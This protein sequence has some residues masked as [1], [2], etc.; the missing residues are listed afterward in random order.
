MFGR[1]ACDEW[2]QPMRFRCRADAIMKCLT[3]ARAPGPI[4][5]EHRRERRDK[6]AARIDVIKAMRE[7]S[8][9]TLMPCIGKAR[10][11]HQ[12]RVSYR[13]KAI[14]GAR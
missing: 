9:V 7:Q 13:H 11:A 8:E 2:G 10:A 3:A 4:G 14:Q 1:E 6:E 12:R 5:W